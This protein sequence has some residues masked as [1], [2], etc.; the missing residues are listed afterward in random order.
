MTNNKIPELKNV[1]FISRLFLFFNESIS[2]DKDMIH[3]IQE[4]YEDI[5]GMSGIPT[6][7]D[8]INNV[9]SIDFNRVFKYLSQ[10][11]ETY[12]KYKFVF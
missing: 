6:L 8:F 3:E 7:E 2:L 9:K 1:I 10:S 12:M 5:Q 11:W 4:I